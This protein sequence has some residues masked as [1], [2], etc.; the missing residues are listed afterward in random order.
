MVDPE[1]HAFSVCTIDGQQHH[2]GDAQDYFCVQ[3]S[4]KPINYCIALNNCNEKFVHQHVGHEP[5]SKSFNELTLNANGLPHNPLINAGAIMTC[6]MIK[7]ELNIADRFEYVQGIWKSMSDESH[8]G[9]NNSVYPSERQTA[10]RNFA[11]GY[12]MR[13]NNDFPK[14]TNLQ[15]ILEFYFQCCSLEINTKAMAI[16]ASTLA[17]GGVCLLTGKTVFSSATVK[18]CLALMYSCGM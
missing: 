8:I 5:N 11:L 6:S 7:P 2:I 9:F 17:N 18:H 3:S 1:K 12:F 14:N 4:C 10:D 13:E 15:K 16:I